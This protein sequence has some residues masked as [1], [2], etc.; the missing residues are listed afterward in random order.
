MRSIE[1]RN[2]NANTK[3]AKVKKAAPLQWEFLWRNKWLTAGATSIDDM[4]KELR[5]AAKEL[6]QM[7][8]NGVRLDPDSDIGN[9]YATLITRNRNVAKLYFMIAVDPVT[10]EQRSAFQ[11]GKY[12]LTEEEKVIL[13]K[14]RGDMLSP[15]ADAVEEA[16]T[17]NHHYLDEIRLSDHEKELERELKKLNQRRAPHGLLL[18]TVGEW[19]D[20]EPRPTVRELRTGQRKLAKLVKK[21]RAQA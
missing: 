4:I 1:S 8:R 6:E 18:E 20:R 7:K 12:P 13:R 17:H 14:L 10:L 3:T 2:L 9:D 21:R 16:W 11:K 19:V 15:F 5:R